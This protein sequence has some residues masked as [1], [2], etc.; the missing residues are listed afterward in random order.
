MTPLRLKIFKICL[1]AFI[2]ISNSY[3]SD[4]GTS[5]IISTPSARMINDGSW[6]YTFSGDDVAFINNFT[7]QALPWLQTTFRYSIF[8]PND[9]GRD[10]LKDR[11]FGI[12]TQIFEENRYIPQVSIGIRDFL[13]TG[14]F[15]SEYLVAS[16]KFNNFDVSVGL[17]WG[18]LSDRSSFDNPLGKLNSH[19]FN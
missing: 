11:S 10:D 2:S 7:Y 18:R 13:G 6:K 14:T 9:I 3:S 19:L 15:S 12:K 17:G 16:K 8:D 5:G 1:I 4:F